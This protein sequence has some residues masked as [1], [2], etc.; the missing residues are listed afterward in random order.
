M[1]N[2]MEFYESIMERAKTKFEEKIKNNQDDIDDYLTFI[3][4]SERF[5]KLKSKLSEDNK[6][7]E[8]VKPGRI[9][10]LFGDIIKQSQEM[11]INKQYYPKEKIA[12]MDKNVKR[13]AYMGKKI[14]LISQAEFADMLNLN[15]R[16]IRQWI[17]KGILL[18]PSVQDISNLTNNFGGEPTPKK[19]YF[20][21]E[22]VQ[23]RN[24]FKKHDIKQGKKIREEFI[25]EVHTAMKAIRDSMKNVD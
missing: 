24:L 19:Y 18:P 12:R 6:K 13:V 10:E 16:T 17:K 21:E 8:P 7:N 1:E 25:A 11:E 15:P 9:T 4:L 23:V 5:E 22:A 14:D 2:K 20:F 3:S